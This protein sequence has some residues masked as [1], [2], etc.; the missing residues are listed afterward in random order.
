MNVMASA[1]SALCNSDL[2]PLA[3]TSRT[4]L[5]YRLLAGVTSCHRVPDRSLV[6]PMICMFAEFT[7]TVCVE[8]PYSA[9]L[10]SLMHATKTILV[11]THSRKRLRAVSAELLWDVSFAS[12]RIEIVAT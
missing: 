10:L 7:T 9:H 8:P 5:P 6:Q 11:L 4:P 3:M 2:Q 1:H 12:R